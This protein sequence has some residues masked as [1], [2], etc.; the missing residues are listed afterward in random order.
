MFVES[1]KVTQYEAC[2]GITV[3]NWKK[4]KETTQ[5]DFEARGLTRTQATISECNND[6][7]DPFYFVTRYEGRKAFYSPGAKRVAFNA[8]G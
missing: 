3:S 2:V 6:E 1:T 8:K 5:E 4:G 7:N